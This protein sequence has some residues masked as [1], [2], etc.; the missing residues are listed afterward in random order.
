[1][2][3]LR[4]PTR[5][6]PLDPAYLQSLAT[7][8]SQEIYFLA[9]CVGRRR[10]PTQLPHHVGHIE[11]LTL[12]VDLTVS[13]LEDVADTHR[14]LATRRGNPHEL[15]LVCAPTDKLHN[16]YITG[17]VQVLHVDLEVRESSGVHLGDGDRRIRAIL[18][19]TVAARVGVPRVNELPKRIEIAAGDSFE[20]PL[21]YVSWICHGSVSF[22][23]WHPALPG[24]IA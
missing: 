21:R 24:I 19:L 23:T 2:D 12:G 10:L 7:Y 1:M 9:S 6:S 4:L 3:L 15:P 13:H 5:P 11:I 14:H 18:S 22:S 20:V 8:S 16:D 17:G